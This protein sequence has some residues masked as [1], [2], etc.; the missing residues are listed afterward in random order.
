MHKRGPALTRSN[1]TLRGHQAAPEEAAQREGILYKRSES[2]VINT[3]QKRYCA[4]H[5]GL[6]QMG[7]KKVRARSRRRPLEAT[8]A[9]GDARS[10]RAPLRPPGALTCGAHPCAHPARS[11]RPL[12]ATP[13]RPPLRPPGMLTGPA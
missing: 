7:E 2:K 1:F 6:F 13:L 12:E 10:R 9:R 5:G 3:F 11:P 8:P 4:I